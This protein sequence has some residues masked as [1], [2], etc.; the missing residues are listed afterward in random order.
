MLGFGE[1][2]TLHLVGT[3]IAKGNCPRGAAR[4]NPATEDHIHMSTL[5]AKGNWNIARGKVKQLLARLADD[6]QQ[7]MEGKEDELV[8]RIQKRTSQSWKK[9]CAPQTQAADASPNK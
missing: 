3:Q 4:V 2:F 7:F 8:G 9:M 1:I 5:A 6:D